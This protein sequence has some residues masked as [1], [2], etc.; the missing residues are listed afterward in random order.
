MCQLYCYPESGTSLPQNLDLVSARLSPDRIAL[1]Y[2]RWEQSCPGSDARSLLPIRSLSLNKN[3]LLDTVIVLLFNTQHATTVEHCDRV[4]AHEALRQTPDGHRQTRRAIT[5]RIDPPRRRA[6]HRT[7]ARESG[8]AVTPL[9][10]QKRL[11]EIHMIASGR[12]VYASDFGRVCT[13]ERL[14]NMRLRL[15]DYD[16]DKRSL[17]EAEKAGE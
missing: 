11:R 2:R 8:E 16:Y 14:S 5:L 17:R 10:M 1:A 7:S 9:E 13:I 12:I 6:S 4:P 15:R 3:R